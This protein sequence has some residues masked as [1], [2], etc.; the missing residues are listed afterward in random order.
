[1]L[2]CRTGGVAAVIR[3]NNVRFSYSGVN[4]P[5]LD[6]VDLDINDGDFI[7]VAGNS[8]AGK[9]TLLRCLN[10][11]VPHFY[12]GRFGGRV[13][14]NRV[15]VLTGRTFREQPVASQG[16][17]PGSPYPDGLHTLSAAGH[18]TLVDGNAMHLVRD[19]L[20]RMLR[21]ELRFR[22]RRPTPDGGGR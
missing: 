21:R 9:S 6:R 2:V 15:E 14:V 3:F 10:G 20:P 17:Q 12:G 8:G 7:L 1:M 5:A 13:V 11:L 18:R 19:A 4:R 22:S 16:P